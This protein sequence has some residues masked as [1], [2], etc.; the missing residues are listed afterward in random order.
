MGNRRYVPTCVGCSR[1]RDNVP[2][3]FRIHS[4][5]M[6]TDICSDCVEGLHLRAQLEFSGV[7]RVIAETGT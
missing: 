6:P 4:G 7:T 1:P 3:L 2:I 5:G